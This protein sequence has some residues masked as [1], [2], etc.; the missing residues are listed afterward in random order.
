MKPSNMD[1]SDTT[2]FPDNTFSLVGFWQKQ[3]M[4][5]GFVHFGMK[6]LKND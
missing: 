6:N 2:R 3:K 1:H 5:F 4:N